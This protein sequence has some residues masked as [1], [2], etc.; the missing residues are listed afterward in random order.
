ME[1]NPPISKNGLP[2][3]SKLSNV[4]Q[5]AKI[6]IQDDLLLFSSTSS[7]KQLFL[8]TDTKEKGLEQY[9]RFL[10]IKFFGSYELHN[11]DKTS[12]PS[13]VDWLFPFLHVFFIMLFIVVCDLHFGVSFCCPLLKQLMILSNY[14]FVLSV[15]V[16]KWNMTKIK[17]QQSK[18]QS[19]F[20]FFTSMHILTS[21]NRLTI[22]C[23]IPTFKCAI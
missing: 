16:P 11:N 13:S 3:N 23:Y 5:A 10:N 15:L 20:E 9:F 22:N 6:S 7:L 2:F 17:V 8:F 12:Q 1:K 19:R 14:I 21:L 4:K 18:I